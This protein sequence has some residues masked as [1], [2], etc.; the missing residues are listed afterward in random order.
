MTPDATPH[1]PLAEARPHRSVWSV[2]TGWRAPATASN[3]TELGYESA[4]PWTLGEEAP[5]DGGEAP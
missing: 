3:E 1:N 4:L 2:L 5:P